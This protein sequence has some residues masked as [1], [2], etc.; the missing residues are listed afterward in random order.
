[1]IVTTRSGAIDGANFHVRGIFETSIREFDNQYTK[2][3]LTSAQ[4]MLSVGNSV[5]SLLVLL[6]STDL[7]DASKAELTKS[8]APQNFEVLDWEQRGDFYRNGRDLLKQINVVVQLIFAALILFSI[9]SSVNM[10]FFE[11]IR[12]FGTM[13]ALGNSKQFIFL[14]ISAE[15]LLVGSIGVMVVLTSG[16]LL[17]S[18]VS[19]LKVMMPALPGSTSGYEAQ[20]LLSPSLFLKVGLLGVFAS[21][22]SSLIVSSR[23]YRLKIVHALGYL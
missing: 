23:A 18:V 10:T 5:S 3:N 15:T 8:L 1:M 20:I 11:R 17:A 4:K 21:L 14:L 2:I 6:R 16:Y 9:A 22:A 12:E 13:M 19:N 7:T